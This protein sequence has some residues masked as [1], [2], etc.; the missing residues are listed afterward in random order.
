V[1]ESQQ[2]TE[3][4]SI[5]PE[6]DK[7]LWL[8]ADLAGRLVALEDPEAF[9]EQV[10]DY[11]LQMFQCQSG[12]M[13]LWDTGGGR[14]RIGP[15]V[16]AAG[17]LN[18][19]AILSAEPVA[20]VVVGQRRPLVMASPSQTLALNTPDWRGM[21]IVP[22]SDAEAVMGLLIIGDL[23]DG[24]SFTESDAALMAAL[25]GL[26]ASVLQTH[27]EFA[28]FREEMGRRMSDAMAELTKAA[29]ELQRLK[30]FNEEL[31]D[32]APV[33]II[34]FDREFR[35]TFRNSAADRLWPEDRS[36]LAGVRRTDL[37]QRDPGWDAALHDVIHMQRPY[38]AEELKFARRTG[39]EVRVTVAC[40]PLFTAAGMVAGG[41]LIVE[42]VTQ[43]IRME[44]RLAVSERLAGVGRLAAMV[45]HEI[46][47]PL[48]GILRLVGLARR[49][50]AE[51]GNERI[52]IYLADAHKGLMRMVAIVR[53]LLEFS[54]TA[55]GS[56]EPRPI[57]E[58]LTEAAR[59]LAP[60]AEKAGVEIVVESDPAL[61]PLKSGI[62]HQV[63]LNLL[64]NAIEVMPA[65]GRIEVRA[66]NQPDAVVIEV[67]DTGPGLPPDVLKHLFEPFYSA[68]PRGQ[69]TGLGLAIC[70][71]LIEKQGG[72]IAASNRPK[73]GAVFT[74]RLPLARPGKEDDHG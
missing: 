74:L 25:G 9:Q 48:D 54:R 34:V 40:S 8:L 70:K 57:G 31:F 18:P 22:I 16:G 14:L 33:G 64:K 71:D 12:C 61:P 50:G 43:R 26:A 60:A 63:V 39:G 23:A 13:C 7:G 51:G 42:D 29:A 21:A 65:G 37:A 2:P 5:R 73:G 10:L 11:A 56:V 30:T 52:E 49:V 28:T 46:N 1:A 69:G 24:R 67:A 72:T 45:A 53:D 17:R 36:V 27:L 47:N 68:K 15:S 55:A 38:M 19:E 35:I 62:L 3:D 6:N 41:V 4:P 59:T 32:S 58:T 44:E 66:K 20:S